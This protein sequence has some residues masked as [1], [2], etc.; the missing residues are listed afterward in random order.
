MMRSADAMP[1]RLDARLLE[2]AENGGSP[3]ANELLVEI[4]RRYNQYADLVEAL[5]VELL[6]PCPCRDGMGHDIECR[7]VSIRNALE[8]AGDTS[9]RERVRLQA[10]ASMAAQNGAKS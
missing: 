10:I 5:T 2:W 1:K 7:V 9:Y 6:R 8:A 3:E 4:I